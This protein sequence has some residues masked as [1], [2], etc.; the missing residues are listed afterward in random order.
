MDKLF[1]LL[2]LMFATI[3]NAQET[4]KVSTIYLNNGEIYKGNMVDYRKGEFLVLKRLN[5]D[6][7]T[8]ADSQIKKIEQIE[9]SRRSAVVESN[10]RYDRTMPKKDK[11]KKKR[12]Y[13]FRETGWYNATGFSGFGGRSGNYLKMGIGLSTTTGY[14]FNRYLGVGVGIAKDNYSSRQ[15]EGLYPVFAEVR[16]YLKKKFNAPYYAVRAG[17]GFAFENEKF[18]V[19]RAEGGVMLNPSVGYRFGGDKTGNI[20]FEIGYKFQKQFIERTSTFNSDVTVVDALYNR[21]SLSAGIIF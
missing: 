10:K 19:T 5:G 16:G 4:P 12:K 20:Y 13:Q 7:D 14:M 9:M 2:L 18:G 11:A 1:L 8:I 6:L 21:I 15:G 17:Y 3:L